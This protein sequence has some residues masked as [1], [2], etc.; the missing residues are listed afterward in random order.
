LRHVECRERW[1]KSCDI[2]AEQYRPVRDVWYESKIVA[3]FWDFM[4]LI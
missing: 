4:A 3:P 2:S 1:L